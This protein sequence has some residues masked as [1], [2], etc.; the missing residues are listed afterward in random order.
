MFQS[1]GMIDLILNLRDAVKSSVF[2]AHTT[3]K[4]LFI[5]KWLFVAPI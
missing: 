2:C 4:E 1:D 5:A 3:W